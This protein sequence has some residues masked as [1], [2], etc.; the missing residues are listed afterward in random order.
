MKKQ[1]R[2]YSPIP[3]F[4]WPEFSKE[5]IRIK[6]Y[7]KRFAN[8]PI[9]EAMCGIKEELTSVP[10]I[11][12]TPVIGSFIEVY[13]TKNDK[14]VTLS[15][16][17]SKETIVCRNNLARYTNLNLQNEKVAAK[18]VAY[19][20]VRQTVTIDIFQA[21]FEKWVN[22]IQADK[23]IQ[24]NVKA[25]KI[26]TVHN[27]R[28]SNGGFIGKAEVPTITEFLGEPFTVDA[29]IPGSQIVLNIESNFEQWNGKTIDTFVAGY[30]LKP[31]TVNQMSLICSRKSLLNF[32]G[33]MSKIKLF[34][35]YCDNNEQWEAFTKSEFV[36]IVTGTIN[37]AKKTGVFVEIPFFN[38]TGMIN[39]PVSRLSEFPDGKQVKVRITDFEQ[40]TT[41][42]SI[43]GQMV[44]SVPYV[45]ENDCL[46]SCI[47]KP[48]L[49][50]A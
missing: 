16:Y 27:L 34:S 5:I 6:E 18:V 47:L 10:E 43:T 48:I 49:E 7:T 20:K 8:I 41:F 19:D 33:N 22:E 50:L 14:N 45:I 32:Y 23:T 28:L 25:P 29:F 35:D 36:G 15:G 40:M 39:T 26:V 42:D 30:T 38:I 1:T 13:V 12:V 44:H 9:A 3:D 46:K 21:M 37:S 17:S 11:P 4:E 31:G 24:Y 2:E